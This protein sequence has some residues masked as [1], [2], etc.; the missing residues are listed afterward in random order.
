MWSIFKKVKK[1]KSI[2]T[3]HKMTQMLKLANKDF[4]ATNINTFKDL[5]E[6]GPN[7]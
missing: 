1:K 4:K 2:E 6:H 3:D 7:N 5:K